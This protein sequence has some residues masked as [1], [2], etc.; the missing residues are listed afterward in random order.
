MK[1]ILLCILGLLGHNILEAQTPHKPSATS[2]IA[3]IPSTFP[4]VQKDFKAL[5]S[6]YGYRKHPISKTIKL[7]KGVD[8][9]AAKGTAVLTTASG[10][11]QKSEYQKGY[12][13]YILLS[14]L[15]T[16]Q[17][18]YAHLWMPLVKKGDTVQQGQ[19]IGFVG[20]TGQATAA[21]LHYEIRIN[22]KTLDPMRL[23]KRKI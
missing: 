12:G 1:T 20:A 4:L 23:W 3:H 19:I 18:L 10:I 6:P 14:H 7:H 16:V 17:T 15:D 5:S 13:N 8:L 21:H 11:V 22:N 9:V 2:N